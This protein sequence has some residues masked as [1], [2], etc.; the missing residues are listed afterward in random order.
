[1]QYDPLFHWVP[2]YQFYP[3]FHR[4]ALEIHIILQKNIW[5]S[6]CIII[7]DVS[8]SVYNHHSISILPFN[9]LSYNENSP[10]LFSGT[11][12]P[13]LSIYE[14]QPPQRNEIPLNQFKNIHMRS[15]RPNWRPNCTGTAR[16]W[17]FQVISAWRRGE[18]GTMPPHQTGSP[19]PISRYVS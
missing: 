14:K 15:Q 17:H 2:W 19:P 9:R 10:W 4:A 16:L 11:L 7:S 1:M 6:R 5:L 18:P 13:S 12:D 8:K 3:F